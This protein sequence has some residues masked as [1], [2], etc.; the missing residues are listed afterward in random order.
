MAFCDNAELF[1]VCCSLGRGG[2]SFHGVKTL[3]F[4][5]KLPLSIDK[6][7]EPDQHAQYVYN[8]A[9]GDIGIYYAGYVDHEGAD[10]CLYSCLP[11]KLREWIGPPENPKRHIPSLQ[12][13]LGPN[14]CF[15]AFDR[16]GF[17]YEKLPS[18]MRSF[19]DNEQFEYSTGGP[20]LVALGPGTSYL[21]VLKSG[22]YSY[23]L[24]DCSI[25][26]DQEFDLLC[27]N[28]RPHEL[29]GLVYFSMNCYA[30]GVCSGFF[31]DPSNDR[32]KTFGEVAGD[33]KE[34]LE[35]LTSG[36]SIVQTPMTPKETHDGEKGCGIC[37]KIFE[38]D[39]KTYFCVTCTHNVCA[40]C[41]ET[42]SFEHPH[43]MIR[44]FLRRTS[45]KDDFWETT[46]IRQATR[47]CDLCKEQFFEELSGHLRCV[48]CDDFDICQDCM[49]KDGMRITDLQHAQCGFPPDMI[50]IDPEAK[51]TEW[52]D[53]QI[54]QARAYKEALEA[55]EQRRE[56]EERRKAEERAR[57]QRAQKQPVSN[58][59]RFLSAPQPRPVARAPSPQP[60]RQRPVS[61]LAPPPAPQTAQRRKSSSGLAFLNSALKLTN[62]VLRAENAANGGWNGGGSVG[63]GGGGGFIDTSGTMDMSSFWDPIN[64]AASDP[65]Q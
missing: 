39:A 1:N 55:A 10:K 15:F 37:Y 6:L 47:T 57:Q 18:V 29:D 3:I 64:S 23:D 52:V 63:G 54:T 45:A 24:R 40:S 2:K 22:A 31:R 34:V 12:V 61:T 17:I 35:E 4:R 19:L 8:I 42:G 7:F 59:S 65:I 48:S 56:A 13:I 58:T 5:E 16:G 53:R 51:G 28:G 14:G 27:T 62:A 50:Y 9:L 32:I 11:P 20:R 43:Q 21:I 33:W 44:V 46:L 41:Y 49:N 60:Q 26:L 36:P 30:P 25:Q 38:K